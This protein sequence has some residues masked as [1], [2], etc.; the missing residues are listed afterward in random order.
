VALLRK[1]TCNLRHPTSL[2]HPVRW[3]Y[4]T[5]WRRL[6]GCLKL[7]VI[8][9]KRATNYTAL[10]Q[11]LT[12]K[13]W[14]PMTPTHPVTEIFINIS[15]TLYI[16]HMGWPRLVGAFKL[17]VSFAKELYN[18]DDILQKRPIVLR[19]L[20]IIATPYIVLLQYI[21]CTIICYAY[22]KIDVWNVD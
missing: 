9:R 8:L 21:A 10:L 19:S 17:Q 14:H 4:Y 12:C 1:M 15:V 13:I 16:I 3:S 11:K 18:W 6:I 2:R 20:L 5:G 7:Q 22:R